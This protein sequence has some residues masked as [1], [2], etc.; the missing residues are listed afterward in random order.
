MC[1]ACENNKPGVEAGLFCINNCV[2][3]SHF[4]WRPLDVTALLPYDSLDNDRLKAGGFYRYPFSDNARNSLVVVNALHFH[5][6]T[7]S[8]EY[9]FVDNHTGE[10]I[11]KFTATF[12]RHEVTGHWHRFNNTPIL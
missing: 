8:M 9:Q 4:K 2:A 5:G 11:N 1:Q 12:R 6:A 7:I 10:R 3:G